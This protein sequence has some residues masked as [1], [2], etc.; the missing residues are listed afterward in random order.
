MDNEDDISA[1]EEIQSKG[2]WIQSKNEHTGRKKSIGCQ[3]SKREKT[4]ISLGRIFV[5]FSSMLLWEVDE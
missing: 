2:S 1:E 3:K 4:D 5:A